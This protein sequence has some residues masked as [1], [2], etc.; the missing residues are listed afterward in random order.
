MVLAKRISLLKIKIVKIDME[1]VPSFHS[2]I[3]A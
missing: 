2:A 1:D 3:S